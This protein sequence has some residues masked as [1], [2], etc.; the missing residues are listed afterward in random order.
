MCP[1]FKG[2]NIYLVPVIPETKLFCKQ[3]GVVPL[4]W[5]ETKRASGSFSKIVL[6]GKLNKL[7]NSRNKSQSLGLEE[8]T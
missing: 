2:V 8:E 1:L 4:N 5:I 6:S 7:Q 3:M